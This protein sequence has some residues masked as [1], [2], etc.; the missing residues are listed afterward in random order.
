MTTDDLGTGNDVLFIATGVSDGGYAAR[1]KIPS[2]NKVK[3]IVVMREARRETVRF[4]EAVHD[5]NQKT[6][7][8]EA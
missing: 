3:R 8:C 4:I 5:M 1:R 2:N 6:D 7:L